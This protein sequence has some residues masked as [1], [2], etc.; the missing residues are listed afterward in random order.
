MR[1]IAFSKPAFFAQ[2]GFLILLCLVACVTQPAMARDID[3]PRD[4]LGWA[5]ARADEASLSE[6]AKGLPA[7]SFLHG[8]DF[9]AGAM[10]DAGMAQGVQAGL[11]LHGM[12]HCLPGLAAMRGGQAATP[13][14]RLVGVERP[15]PSVPTGPSTTQTMCAPAIRNR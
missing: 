4:F 6:T 14:I 3:L 8:A 1:A 11:P 5:S 2:A 9:C 13:S 15:V 7:A 12:G 10:L